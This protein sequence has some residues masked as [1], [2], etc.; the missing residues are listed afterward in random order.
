MFA[1]SLGT[2]HPDRMQEVG[3]TELVL[4]PMR[5]PSYH[6]MLQTYHKMPRSSVHVIKA[7]ALINWRFVGRSQV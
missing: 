6:M 5:V 3:L 1:S 2:K 4:L 7:P